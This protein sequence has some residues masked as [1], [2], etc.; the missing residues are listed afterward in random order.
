MSKFDLAN[1]LCMFDESLMKIITHLENG[2]IERALNRARETHKA[3]DKILGHCVG[4]Y[5]TEI[6]RR[7]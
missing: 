7:I 4:D 6:E 3:I 2:N 1:L 5:H